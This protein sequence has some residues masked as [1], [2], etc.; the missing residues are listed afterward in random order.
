MTKRLLISL[1]LLSFSL[2]AS[3]EELTLN[4]ALKKLQSDNIELQIAKN[5]V[6]EKSLAV[7]EARSHHF[8]SLDLTQNYLVS[9]DVGKVFGFKMTTKDLTYGLF[10][11]EAFLSQLST[12]IN[13]GS[14]DQ[15]AQAEMLKTL[16]AVDIKNPAALDFFQT[17]L[18]YKLPLYAGGKISAGVLIAKKMHQL[19]RLSL[20]EQQAQKAFEVKKSFYNIVLLNTFLNELEQIKKNILALENVTKQMVT[21]GYAKEIDLLEIESKKASVLQN[22]TESQ[23]YK[24][25]AL[26]YL[27]FLLNQEVKSVNTQSIKALSLPKQKVI[28][29]KLLK[30][31]QAKTGVAIT[32]EMR[33]IAF[34]GALPEVGAFV[35][36]STADNTFLGNFEDHLVYTAGA[37]LKWNLFDGFGTSAKYQKAKI[38]EM[39][40]KARYKL[41]IEGLKLQI[42]KL[43]AHI[44]A[45]DAKKNSLETQIT[46]N[47]KIVQNYQDRYA[48]KL[49][50]INDVMIAQSG[51]IEKVL[52]LNKINNQR[53]QK[54]LELLTLTE[55]AY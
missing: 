25:L 9:T 20:K 19:S 22:I 44:T 15:T 4:D 2:Q 7:K 45:L 48:E 36:T 38:A 5:S 16:Q 21:E 55:G 53:N 43:K 18:S 23:T 54:I 8:G 6:T 29:A 35:E 41:A 14:L 33:S 52:K 11:Y 39:N 47:K 24:A 42:A 49:S 31:Q 3:L 26:Q 13:S 27:S 17:K 10:D 46:L 32:N 37:Q 50:S 1:L 34:S 30:V 40:A 51:L 28:T 12:A